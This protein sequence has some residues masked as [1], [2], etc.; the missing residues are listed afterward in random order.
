[1]PT[2]I[3]SLF[4]DE[5]RRIL[6][7]LCNT[8]LEEAES[9]FRQLHERYDPLMRFH[10]RLGI[11]LPKVLQMAAEFDVNIQL[12][13]LL[14]GADLPLPEIEARLRE[15]QEERVTLDETTLMAL[16]NAIDRSADAFSDRPDDLDRLENYETIVS[17]SRAMQLQ[18]NLRKPQD[19][20]YRMMATVRPAIAANGSNGA[21]ARWLDL[22]D[23]L[24]EK[25]AISPEA[26]S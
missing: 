26:R 11:P 10:A 17:I 25:L 6:K 5:Q 14:E 12:R 7:A 18:V 13:R 19:E 20:Y 15:A 23:S 8:T 2:S 21:T 22:F 16:E 4:R 3:R 1:M 24:G 9:A